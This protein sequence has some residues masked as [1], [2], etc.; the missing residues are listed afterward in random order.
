[1]LVL[2]LIIYR[3]Q[4][5]AVEFAACKIGSGRQRATTQQCCE[6]FQDF[7]CCGCT[8]MNTTLNMGIIMDIGM[9]AS[10]HIFLNLEF[11]P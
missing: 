6:Y 4:D 8:L 7:T 1:M 2:Y 9:P 10:C 11:H 5:S 3:G